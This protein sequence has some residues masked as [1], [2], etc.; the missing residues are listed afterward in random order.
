MSE[1]SRASEYSYRPRDTPRGYGTY[2]AGGMYPTGVW[3][4]PPG[5]MYTHGGYG[6]GGYPMGVWVWGHRIHISTYVYGENYFL[7]FG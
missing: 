1:I 6:Y 5:G 2:R 7:Q 3:Y 4:V